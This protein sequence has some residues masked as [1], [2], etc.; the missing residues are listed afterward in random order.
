[1][2]TETTPQILVD[3]LDHALRLTLSSPRT[4]NALT[5]GMFE[6]LIAALDDAAQDPSVRAV[7]LRG[8]DGAFTSGN[9]MAEFAQ[10]VGGDNPVATR[11]L[12]RLAAFPKPIVAQVEGPAIAIGTTVLLHCDMVFASEDAKFMLP[13][14]SLGVV[15]EAGS[16]YLLPKLVGHAKAAELL[17]LGGKFDAAEALDIGLVNKVLPAAEL[18]DTVAR[19]VQKLCQ[20]PP[21]ALAKAKALVRKP[22]GGGLEERMAEEMAVFETCFTGAEYAEVAAAMREKRK[23]VFK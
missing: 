3:R 11:F 17:Y 12:E 18:E 4:K 6:A 5:I 22:L 7:W 14:V 15:P 19:T 9:V 10:T 8:A 13:F 20:Q 16:T 2:S 1:M 21:E 23:P